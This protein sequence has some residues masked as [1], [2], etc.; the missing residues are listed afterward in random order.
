MNANNYIN[1]FIESSQIEFQSFY[2]DQNPPQV[3]LGD[4]G[5]II[6]HINSINKYLTWIQSTFA[7][8]NMIVNACN[9]QN[10]VL[11]R[12]GTG[13]GPQMSQYV[14][15][16]ILALQNKLE[17]SMEYQKQRKWD[18]TPFRDRDS[19]NGKTIGIMGIGNIGCSIAK[20]AKAFD[21]NTLG[22]RSIGSSTSDSVFD[23]YTSSL[24]DLLRTCNIIVNVLPSTPS[25]KYLLSD[26][27]LDTY[28]SHEIG[29]NE[30]KRRPIFI[31]IGRGD[32]IS[33]SVLIKA[34]DMDIFQHALLDVT[35]I[36][37]LPGDHILW[38]HQK[39]TITPHISA[40]STPDIICDVFV[41]NMV[42]YLQCLQ[43]SREQQSILQR[44]QDIINEEFIHDLRNQ[45]FHVV[46]FSKGY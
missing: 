28:Q 36:E 35:E 12:I 21:M 27:I 45:L 24:H 38:N 14:F 15:G 32:I 23:S 26:D 33:S 41:K 8:V 19:I 31:N 2:D 42:Q 5:M 11:S 29:T 40:I 39:V 16:W 17:L 37:P 10:I 25:T 20:T 1:N 44:P 34:L 13:F 7:G 6:P 30:H 3:V 43:H 22:Y 18:D 46:D 4:P 9:T